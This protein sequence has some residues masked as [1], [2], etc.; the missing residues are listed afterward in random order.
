[1]DINIYNSIMEE[2][3]IDKSEYDNYLQLAKTHFINTIIEY[4]NIEKISNEFK[5]KLCN[6]K[7]KNKEE[8]DK[9]NNK[10]INIDKDILVC[11]NNLQDEYKVKEMIKENGYKFGISNKKINELLNDD[12]EDLVK[13][14]I[15][16]KNNKQKLNKL[17]KERNKIQ[18]HQVINNNGQVYLKSDIYYE[19]FDDILD[20]NKWNVS[21][22][23]INYNEKCN[24]KLDNV[25]K[26]SKFG[27]SVRKYIDKRED[28]YN[29]I[30]GCKCCSNSTYTYTYCII[31]KLKTDN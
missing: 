9:Y 11:K 21:Y 13:S 19:I 1:M 14:W 18:C 17:K 12:N 24:I 8:Y 6:E 29:S 20:I 31:L 5:V 22:D 30:Y 4:N 2:L 25:E 26:F 27:W 7:K 3:G 28:D 15:F 16:I 23:G 10:L